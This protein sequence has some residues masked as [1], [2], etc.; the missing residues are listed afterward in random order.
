MAAIFHYN[1]IGVSS[2]KN[3]NEK[4]N[5]KKFIAF[6]PDTKITAN[7]HYNIIGVSSWRRLTSRIYE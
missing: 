4:Q 1:V 5:E 2:Q 7:C 6:A 3:N